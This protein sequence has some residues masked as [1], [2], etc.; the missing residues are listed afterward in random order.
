M[1]VQAG[2]AVV[3]QVKAAPKMIILQPPLGQPARVA[4]GVV[5]VMN[6]GQEVQVVQGL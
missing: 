3:A 6:S 4:E 1:V 2:V 5:V